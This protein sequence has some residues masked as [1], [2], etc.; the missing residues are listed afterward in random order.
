M[1]ALLT[2]KVGMFLIISSVLA[3]WMLLAA[4]PGMAHQ[5]R[6][7]ALPAPNCGT[8]PD[9]TRV[10]PTDVFFTGAQQTAITSAATAP[11]GLQTR[12][13]IDQAQ[14]RGDQRFHYAKITIPTLAAGE[15]RVFDSTAAGGATQTNDGDATNDTTPSDA[16]LCRKGTQIA[17][18]RETYTGAHYSAERAAAAAQ[19]AADR[20]AADVADLTPL[21]TTAVAALPSTPT[22]TPDQT[23][24]AQTTDADANV[25]SARN[26]LT[27]ARS[28]LIA[29]ETALRAAARAAF[30][31]ADKA[32][33]TSGADTAEM[34]ADDVDD[35]IDDLNTAVTAA[36]TTATTTIAAIPADA[37]DRADQ[38]RTA[39]T[40]QQQS[41][42]TAAGTARDALT[43]AA[44]ALDAAAGSADNPATP[45]TS[46]L[47]WAQQE[48]TGF[49]LRAPVSPGDEEY[50]VVVA[51]PNT[52]TSPD[53]AMA[54]V[55]ALGLNVSFHG[56][57]DTTATADLTGRLQSDT[58]PDQYTILTNAAGL[59]TLGTT[60]SVDTV[61]VLQQGAN[62]IAQADSGGTGDNFKIDVPLP[63]ETYT[64]SVRGNV[65]EVD[66]GN[67]TL[68]M[69]FEVAMSHM[70]T[71]VPDDGADTVVTVLA[72]ADWN[73]AP[74]VSVPDDGLAAAHTPE[75][76]TDQHTNNNPDEDYFAFS[77][78]NTAPTQGFLTVEATG[79]GTAAVDANP[80]GTLYGPRGEIVSDATS[81][82][83]LMRVPVSVPQGSQM[84]HY[85]VKVERGREG[86]YRLKF[87][88]RPAVLFGQGDF[89]GV[90]GKTQAEASC[91]TPGPNDYEICPIQGN[92]PA[93]QEI[94]RFVFDM[95]ETGTLY[96]HTTG[97][98]DTV[99]TLYGPN[100][101][102]IATDN[103]SG[104]GNN[105][106]I[107][108][109]VG[110]GLH[111]LEVRGS[112]R[113][114]EGVYRLVTNF[115]RGEGPPVVEE[116]D[117][118]GTVT[119][120]VGTDSRGS[121]EDPPNNGVRSGI[122]II[123]GWVCQANSVRIQIYD[124]G[125]AVV[126]TLI[127][128]YGTHRPDVLA[129]QE[130]GA[131]RGN[132]G[133]GLT[134]NFNHLDEGTYTI[135]A[136]ADNDQ[137]GLGSP[138]ENTF[139]VVHLRPFSSDDQDRFLRNL[140]TTP[141]RLSDFPAAGDT[142]IV[143]WEESTQSFVIIDVE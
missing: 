125:G 9:D 67:Y 80:K 3:A 111:L 39:R 79:D 5:K 37:P 44:T 62:D 23:L 78:A 49:K 92:D 1:K 57:I 27:R 36:A 58:P 46:L 110:L 122:G 17:S 25:A 103:N 83:F 20:A 113:Q 112:G 116:P 104:D 123:R 13:G 119:T 2:A 71:V 70:P 74:D 56:A 126:E 54:T 134:F 82:G 28:A 96:L 7:I 95:Q 75:I 97:D 120:P 21:P 86:A 31:D 118:T 105:F 133:F 59:L 114:E 45:P 69:G 52:A 102:L 48:H 34:A 30:T 131:R 55:T 53:P 81:T 140:P 15:L 108:A 61:G 41:K 87:T 68:D 72:G 8:I 143:Q 35:A 89:P 90:R 42:N 11:T 124:D 121:L 141:Y 24:A 98:T 40:T 84:N 47:A 94:E 33:L 101:A 51:L 128:G 130:C 29:V 115:I 107:A 73:S 76:K 6:G 99:G 64:L 129:S 60:G 32:N 26:A 127:A 43:P 65:P 88:Y 139:D 10:A 4:G 38:I 77:I 85:L 109:R 18:S 117:D 50:V 135:R 16:I 137:I 100:G 66:V 132:V 136:F 19:D 93:Q 12:R 91:A 106:S 14:R 63:A 142:T 138:Q 22:P